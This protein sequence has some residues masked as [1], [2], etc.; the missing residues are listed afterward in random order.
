MALLP[1][2]FGLPPLPYL[3]V[4][5]LALVGVGV[6]LSRRR[7]PFGEREVLALVPWMC[8]GA[9]LNVLRQVDGVP[10]ALAPLFGTPAVYLSVAALAGAV[11]LAVDAAGVRT[12]RWL[13]GVGALGFVAGLVAVVG[14]GLARGSFDPGPSLVALGV[15]IGLATAAW[16]ALK[17][18]DSSAAVAG[19]AGALALFAHTLDAVSTAVGIDWLGFGERTPLSRYIIE[20]AAGLPTAD[21][22]GA[23]WL[24]IVVKV[25]LVA[26]VVTVLADQVRE[27]PLEGYAL[28][29]AVAA[30]GLGPGVHNLLLF[31]VA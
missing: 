13:G 15:A 18:I 8:L 9:A 28:L 23:G 27:E 25:V 4:L 16:G 1:A 6:G 3:L 12:A 11:W 20:F 26:W 7:P 29:V 24:F 21:L 22:I 31:A 5:V 10:E 19:W 30:V 2:G 14:A 17:R